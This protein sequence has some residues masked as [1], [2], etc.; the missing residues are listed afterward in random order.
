LPQR[1]LF[2]I[3]RFRMTVF[4]AIKNRIA[5]AG[6][7]FEQFRRVEFEQSSLAELSPLR[8]SSVVTNNV[9]HITPYKAAGGKSQVLLIQYGRRVFDVIAYTCPTHVL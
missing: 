1:G 8:M 9:A 5:S 3:R 2:A 6:D 7:S 4:D